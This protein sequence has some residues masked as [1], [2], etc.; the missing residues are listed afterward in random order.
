MTVSDAFTINI[1]NDATWSV[2]DASMGIIDGSRVMLQIV[3]LA[4]LLRSAL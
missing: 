2:N 3:A 4:P 1:I